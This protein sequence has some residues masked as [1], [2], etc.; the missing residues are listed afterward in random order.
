MKQFCQRKKADKKRP[1]GSSSVSELLVE[2][3]DG[4]LEAVEAEA[5]TTV[6]SDDSSGISIANSTDNTRAE[7][8]CPASSSPSSSEHRILPEVD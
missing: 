7:R 5:T 2:N 6:S 4:F 3:E 1:M 8:G